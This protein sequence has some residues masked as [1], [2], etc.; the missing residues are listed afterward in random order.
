MKC[1]R[2]SGELRDGMEVS[3]GGAYRG[4]QATESG[5]MSCGVAVYERSE[6]AERIGTAPVDLPPST[7]RAARAAGIC[8]SGWICRG[9]GSAT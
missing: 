2:C 1:P 4:G 9:T 3:L 6:L 8:A 7:R 5:C